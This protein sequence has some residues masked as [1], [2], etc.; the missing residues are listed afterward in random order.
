MCQALFLI[1]LHFSKK[2][3]CS[4]YTYD[5]WIS[6][7][8]SFFITHTYFTI[9]FTVTVFPYLSFET[10][11]RAVFFFCFFILITYCFFLFT[12]DTPSFVC[13]PERCTYAITVWLPDAVPLI[14]VLLDVTALHEG[15]L[16]PV[17]PLQLF[18]YTA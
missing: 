12:D 3:F 4:F 16:M 13:F 6:G 7:T 15:R 1:F 11:F 18:T 8:E 9:V 10:S 2:R 14:A 5:V 17:H